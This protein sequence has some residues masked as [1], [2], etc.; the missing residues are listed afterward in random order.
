MKTIIT[1]LTA[2]ILFSCQNK[3]N[4]TTNDEHNHSE[5]IHSEENN[6][7][8][9]SNNDE[10]NE[11]SE[12][13]GIHLSKQQFDAMNIQL[14]DLSKMKINDYIKATGTLGLPPDAYSNVSA[15]AEGTIKNIKKFVE[16]NFIKKNTLIAYVENISFIKLQQKYLETNAELQYLSQEVDRQQNL[17]NN[18]AGVDKNLQKIQSEYNLKNASL[19]GLEKQLQFLGINTNSLTTENIQSKIPIYSPISG[20][21]TSIKMHNGLYIKPE[22]KLMEIVQDKHIHLELDVF[23]KDIAK[24]KEEQRISYTI[25]ALGNKVYDGEV[26]I[27]G[28]EFNKENKTVRIHGH[29]LNEKPLFIKDLFVDAK[30]WLN[31]ETVSALPEQAIITE[32]TMSYIFITEEKQNKDEIEFEKIQVNTGATNKGYTSVKLT[33]KIPKDHKIVVKGAYFVYA[34]SKSGE[35][36]HEH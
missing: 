5:A 19:K 4:K 9:T 24:I 11:H 6:N 33:E 29:L 16:G 12:D 36:E 1:I 14:G 17:I 18:N 34:Q 23:E 10:H 13:K 31:N 8:N 21:I 15:K 20:Y 2:L 25:P 35:L 27:I 32:G 7:E 30:I 26:H 28:K 22:M 3:E